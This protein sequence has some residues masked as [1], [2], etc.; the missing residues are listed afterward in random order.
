VTIFPSET[1]FP[2]ARDALAMSKNEGPIQTM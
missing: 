2:R 1:P